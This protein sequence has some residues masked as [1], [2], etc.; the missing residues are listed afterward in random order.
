MASTPLHG[1]G[2]DGRPAAYVLHAA[3]F[4]SETRTAVKQRQAAAAAAACDF[5]DGIWLPEIANALGTPAGT[6]YL[7]GDA[8]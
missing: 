4:L 5:T 2:Q 8:V 7:Q 1:Q 3:D 6:G